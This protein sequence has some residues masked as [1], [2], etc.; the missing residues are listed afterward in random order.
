MWSEYTCD[1]DCE[2]RLVL[3]RHDQERMAAIR[4]RSE[5]I[6]ALE[7]AASLGKLYEQEILLIAEHARHRIKIKVPLFSR[8]L[9]LLGLN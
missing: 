8:I 1:Q 6:E 7:A 5:G 2:A 4:S 9:R 3:I